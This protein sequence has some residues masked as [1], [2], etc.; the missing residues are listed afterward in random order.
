M[1]TE[2]ERAQSSQDIPEWPG[3]APERLDPE[4]TWRSDVP[5]LA[6]Y[7]YL[8]V[9]A[10]EGRLTTR[11]A[12]EYR[13]YNMRRWHLTVAQVS[14]S[15]YGVLREPAEW[16][17][18]SLQNCNLLREQVIRN[19]EHTRTESS[20]G[21]RDGIRFTRRYT[22]AD[23]TGYSDEPVA[24]NFE[25]SSAPRLENTGE[26]LAQF[27]PMRQ[28][29]PVRPP[30]G[31]PA[32]TDVPWRGSPTQLTHLIRLQMCVMGARHRETGRAY[33]AT[34]QDVEAYERLR[35]ALIRAWRTDPRVMPA[36]EDRVRWHHVIAQGSDVH[37]LNQA[38][39]RLGMP[40]VAQL[41]TP[42]QD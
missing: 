40:R 9:R 16:A 22:P 34:Q 4:A 15:D 10:A 42:E 13:V 27:R 17:R 35:G 25:T 36:F 20:R 39:E 2:A 41:S 28:A 37:Y 7:A 11:Q 29:R 33:R 24:W 19:Q 30:L 14:R 6:R 1:V 26:L 3:P 18:N 21:L 23:L 8:S 5:H 12:A 38:R 32:S 31:E